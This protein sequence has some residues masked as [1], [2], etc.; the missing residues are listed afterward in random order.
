LIVTK[1]KKEADILS[2]LEGFKN[3][4]IIGCSDCAALCGTGGE[5]ETA[6]M[7]KILVSKGWKVTGT[8][9]MEVPCDLRINR[10][11]FRKHEKEIG[12]SDVLL[13]LSCGAGVNAVGECSDKPVLSGL[14]SVYLGSTERI[15]SF[16]EYCTLCGD[17]VLN[18]TAGICPV[19]RCT[20][21][22]VNGPCGGAVLGYCEANPES[23]CMWVTLYKR[24]SGA[25][26]LKMNIPPRT[27][28]RSGKPHKTRQKA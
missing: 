4:F 25:P 10:T 11:F 14:D 27:N 7:K 16:N 26:V 3:V 8:A 6:E 17:C 1:K 15:G 5:P 23:E 13:V 19:T 24:N 20:K 18:L 2:A 9:V 22:L 12:S 21:G 28:A